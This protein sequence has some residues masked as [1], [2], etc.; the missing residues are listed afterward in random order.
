M[1]EHLVTVSRPQMDAAPLSPDVAVG[2]L[3]RF[4][5][6]YTILEDGPAIM[7]QLLQLMVSVS[8]GGKQVHDA[9]LIATMLAHG[10]SRLLT[11]NEADFRRFSALVA[12]EPVTP[13]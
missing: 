1:S 10:V 4:A 13:A 5:E 3:R 8:I 11:F 9:N 12:L 7:E 6:I 2:D